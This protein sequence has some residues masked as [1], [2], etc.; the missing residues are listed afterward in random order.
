MHAYLATATALAFPILCFS[1]KLPSGKAQPSNI[2][3][4]AYLIQLSTSNI[5]TGRDTREP[6]TTA[7]EAFHK[8]AETS[9]LSCKWRLLSAL[10][11]TSIRASFNCVDWART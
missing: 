2:V 11:M 1:L 10:T 3:D 7:L 4:G 9:Q 5:L 8:R 6:H